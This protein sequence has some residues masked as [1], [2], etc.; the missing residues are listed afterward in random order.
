[1]ILIAIGSNL[2]SVAGSPLETCNAALKLLPERGITVARTSNWYETAPVP[3]SDQPW[4]VNGAARVETT[5]GPDDMLRVLHD[6]EAHFARVRH[7]RNAARTLDL[8][9]L[10]Y[11]DQVRSGEGVQVPHPRLHE[12]AFVLYPLMDVAPGWRHP[13]LGQTVTEMLKNLPQ[14]LEKSQIRP[15]LARP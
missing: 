4:F 1:M 6:V 2:P 10:A 8:D 15:V 3:V 5:L 13:V 11:G 7:E 9:L 12:R 14:G